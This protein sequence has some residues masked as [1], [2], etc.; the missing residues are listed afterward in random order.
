MDTDFVFTPQVGAGGS[1][2][3]A[4]IGSSSVFICG[5]PWLK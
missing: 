5:N 3:L 1:V 2:M 4:G